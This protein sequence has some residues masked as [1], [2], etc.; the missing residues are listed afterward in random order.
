VNELYSETFG[1]MTE[2]PDATADRLGAA[3]GMPVERHR[4]LYYGDYSLCRGSGGGRIRVCRNRD[5]I[6]RPEVHPPEHRFL[7][8]E[9]PADWML[10]EADLTREELLRLREALR[11]EFPEAVLLQSWAPIETDI[12]EDRPRE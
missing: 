2:D 4:S 3:M 6:Y 9:Y 1:L 11:S 8:P 10:L 12:P 5:A 7:R